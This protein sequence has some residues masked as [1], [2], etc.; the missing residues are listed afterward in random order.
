[1]VFSIVI[2]CEDIDLNQFEVLDVR[3]QIYLVRSNQ[4]L[5]PVIIRLNDNFRVVENV[6]NLADQ[7]VIISFLKF[8]FAL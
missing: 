6:E 4:E 3:A 2:D 8:S 5:G 1:M 7:E